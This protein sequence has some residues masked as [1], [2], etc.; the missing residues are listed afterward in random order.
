M[1]Y[2]TRAAILAMVTLLAI[3][4][5][6]AIGLRTSLLAHVD[7]WFTKEAQE[8][9]GVAMRMTMITISSFGNSITL[10]VVALATSLFLA[11][12]KLK[13]AAAFAFAS[14]IGLPIDFGLKAIFARP[15]PG[16]DLV[17][18]LLPASGYSF[19]S[20]HALGSTVVYGF[21]AFLSWVHLKEYKARK[22]VTVIFA[23]LP[24]LISLSRVYVGAHWLSDV[25]AG[26]T[27]GLIV[28]ILMALTY[29]KWAKAA[30]PV[31]PTAGPL[32]PNASDSSSYNA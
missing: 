22:P 8:R 16:Q 31:E 4:V 12:R 27:L 25:V 6:V 10:I 15:R 14:L 30:R 24:L 18:I 32:D 11:S 29:Q 5:A 20:G 13:Q 23:I 7:L 26:V 28:V 21:L 2:R 9:S 3:F 19:P 17:S 1:R